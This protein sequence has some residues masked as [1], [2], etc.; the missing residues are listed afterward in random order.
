MT[1]IVGDAT[2]V[3]GKALS[4][5]PDSGQSWVYDGTQYVPETTVSREAYGF[6]DVDGTTIAADD[7]TDTLHLSGVSGIKFDAVSGTGSG[8]D[9]IVAEVSGLQGDQIPNWSEISGMAD[10]ASGVVDDVSGFSGFVMAS[11]AGFAVTAPAP[12]SGRVLKASG[13]NPLT[14][15]Y[16][17]VDQTASGGE[18][19]GNAYAYIL[20]QGA[21]TLDANAPDDTLNISGRS[22]I[23]VTGSSGAAQGEDVIFFEV[24][25]LSS[26]QIPQWAEIS[27]LASGGSGIAV[28]ASGMATYSSGKLDDTDGTSGFVM[29]SGNGLVV[30]EGP[31]GSGQILKWSGA[32]ILT[33][34]YFAEDGAGA[35]AQDVEQLQNSLIMLA[36]DVDSDDN[37]YSDVVTDAFEDETGIDDAA[38][39]GAVY[40]EEGDY[41]TYTAAAESQ[42]ID[43]DPAATVTDESDASTYITRRDLKG[44][45]AYWQKTSTNKG[46]FSSDS[47][48]SSR[49]TITSGGTEDDVVKGVLVVYSGGS[50]TIVNVTDLGEQ[51][52]ETELSGD[53]A[54][55]TAM[56]AIYGLAVDTA[57]DEIET[58]QV[59]IE[60]QTGT[61]S[62]M[63]TSPGARTSLN[64]IPLAD[65]EYIT[66]VRI[67]CTSEVSGLKIKL[68]SKSGSSFTVDSDVQ[69]VNHGGTGDE[70]FDITTPVQ[71]GGSNIYCAVYFPSGCTLYYD[72]GGGPYTIWNYISG[73]LTGTQTMASIA[74]RAVGI[75]AYTQRTV[76][77]TAL[78]VA[79]TTDN[80]DS[81]ID[82]SN[83]SD[84][85]DGNPVTVT[86]ATPGSSAI[87]HAVAWDGRTEFKVWDS[88]AVASRSIAKDDSGTWK[89]ND[90]A[91]G[92]E[93]WVA[94][95]E[96]SALGALYD[97][98]ETATNKTINQWAKVGVDAVTNA[99]WK[100]MGWSTSVDSIDWAVGLKADSDNAPEFDKVTFTCDQAAVDLSL[101]TNSWEA[102]ENDPDDAYCV[103]M[104]K[105]N[106]A[107]TINTDLKAHVSMDDGANYEQITLDA[108]PFREIGDKDYYRGDISGL[109]ART[110]STMRLKV[111]C[112]KNI[113]IHAIALGVKYL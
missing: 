42:P 12:I 31:S 49:I 83:W 23:A 47:G 52:D 104:I 71:V 88:T 94:A 45:I 91:S 53:I 90:G 14:D 113:E 58:N 97:A 59:V 79:H 63:D 37:S 54:D 100:T 69:T 36:W 110:D 2:H 34:A 15:I 55:A 84:L 39:T 4:G 98:W 48:G 77:P 93:S 11:G 20:V 17:A 25:G 108:S 8:A 29:T 46:Y 80:A 5:T 44:T 107:F 106:E 56:T 21:T 86:Q 13:A 6:V 57:N 99:Q 65:G 76:V 51:D 78:Y 26:D 40:N 82:C 105:P 60:T 89:Y 70:S 7:S 43:L 50:Q 18:G 101:V 3:K 19:S 74:A 1:Q 73:E 87:Y 10:Y 28:G 16:W 22:G 9:S 75:I 92:A 67:C 35:S 66:R 27:G 109:T 85:G 72:G 61:V 103:L 38:S 41:Y 68:L 30:L 95:A 24:S 111:G 33:D 62:N 81:R 112:D 96:N 102:E 64:A 32:N